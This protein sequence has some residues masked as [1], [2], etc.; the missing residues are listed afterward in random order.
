MIT[1]IAFVV[2]VFETPVCRMAVIED[3]DENQITIHK[4]NGG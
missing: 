3:P 4:R 2:D 1:P